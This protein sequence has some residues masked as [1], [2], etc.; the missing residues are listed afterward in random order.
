MKPIFIK[1]DNPYSYGGVELPAGV[2]IEVTPALTIIIP[3]SEILESPCTFEF[4]D[5]SGTKFR[6]DAEGSHRKL[7][8]IFDKLRS[9]QW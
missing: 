1:L 3:I 9:F 5:F 8:F 7:I 6:G 4:N 2:D